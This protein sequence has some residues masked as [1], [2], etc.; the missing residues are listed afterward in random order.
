VPAALEPLAP[1]DP[2][3]IGGYQLRARV[4]TFGSDD[5]VR[6]D[7]SRNSKR[8]RRRLDRSPDPFGI[9]DDLILPNG[10]GLTPPAPA[11]RRSAESASRSAG[12]SRRRL[13]LGGA[14]MSGPLESGVLRAG[15]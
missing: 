14:A 11:D 9:V 3:E 15:P 13:L 8:D 7:T 2:P 10:P 5:L 1:E 6:A 4:V 12:S